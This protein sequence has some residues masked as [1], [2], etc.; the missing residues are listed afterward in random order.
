MDLSNFKERLS[1]LLFDA[2]LNPPAFAKLMN[3]GSNTIT[4]YL[5]GNT[6]PSLT[7]AVRMADYFNCSVD[8]LLGTSNEENKKKYKPCLPFS[9]RLPELCKALNI[10][11]YQLRTDTSLHD[12][13]IYSWQN[14]KTMPSIE[15]IAKIAETYN[16]S[17][18]FIFGRE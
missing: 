9:K 15:S 1:E 17:I 4:R 5:Q 13:A 11:K 7:M 8:Y 2:H 16:C 6:L 3:C 10:T 14:G 18:D 12:N